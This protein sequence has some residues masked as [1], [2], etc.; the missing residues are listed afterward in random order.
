[1]NEK[2]A[3]AKSP[4]QH[5]APSFTLEPP[6]PRLSS[7]QLHAV[8]THTVGTAEAQSLVYYSNG[9]GDLRYDPLTPLTAQKGV[10]MSIQIADFNKDGYA[11]VLMGKTSW[12]GG[13]LSIFMAAP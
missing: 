6:V 7:Q 11:D 8:H 3:L 10:T 9:N 12:G 2:D 13:K 5:A 4:A 1:M